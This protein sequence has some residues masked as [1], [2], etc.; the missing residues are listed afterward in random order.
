M[1]KD[2]GKKIKGSK[3]RQLKQS[4]GEVRKGRS[5]KDHIFTIQ[6]LLERARTSGR[7]FSIVNESLEK[8]KKNKSKKNYN[9]S[10]YK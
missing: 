7:A 5:L 4:H 8:R 3:E 9:E 1:P 6:Q 2:L 10:V